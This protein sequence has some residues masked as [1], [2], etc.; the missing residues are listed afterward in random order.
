MKPVIVISSPF[1]SAAPGGKVLDMKRQGDY[2]EALMLQMISIL[3]LSQS[4]SSFLLPFIAH[5]IHIFIM[6]GWICE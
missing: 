6:A 5:H 4:T 2:E 1:D 3:C